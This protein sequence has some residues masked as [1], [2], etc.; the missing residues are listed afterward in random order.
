MDSPFFL[1]GKEEGI[2]TRIAA[3]PLKVY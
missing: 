3:I 1:R 2:T